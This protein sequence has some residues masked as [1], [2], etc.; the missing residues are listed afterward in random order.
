MPRYHLST[1]QSIALGAPTPSPVDNKPQSPN[2]DT[3]AQDAS[4][5]TRE[6]ATRVDCLTNALS[7][8]WRLATGDKPLSRER[9]KPSPVPR[10][11]LA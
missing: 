7:T 11:P 6:T 4:S 8:D 9:D 10:Q 5:T 2:H 3:W 1:T